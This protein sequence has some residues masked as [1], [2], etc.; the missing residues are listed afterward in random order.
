METNKDQSK[1]EEIY[2][3]KAEDVS[4]KLDLEENVTR[5]NYDGK[6]LIL[7]G[8]AHV[9]KQSVELVK[10][11][12]ETEQPDS[13]CVELDQDRYHSLKNPK[14]WEETDIVQVIKSKK[15]AYLLATL[16]LG[17][18]QRRIA[19]KLDTQVG[20][21]MIQGIESAE[22][23]NANL[24]LADRSIQITFMRIWRKLSFK[25]K[26]KLFYGLVFSSADDADEITDDQLQDLLK[27]DM[28]ESA[29]SE[30][31]G[32]FPII[33]QVLINERDQHLAFKIREAP[34]PKIVAILGA[35]HVPGI[36]EEIYKTSPEDLA[37]ITQ[38]PPKKSYSKAIGWVIPI[39]I[40]ALIVYGFVTNLETGLEQLSSWFLWNS[41]LAG[42]GTLLALGHPLSILTAFVIA[43]F[44]SLNPFL[45]CGWFAGLVEASVRKPT[46]SDVQNVYKDIF[47]LKGIFK[48]RFLKIILVVIMA[49]IGSSIGTIV[50][51]LDIVTNL[52]G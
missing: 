35:A 22:S 31:R 45:A 48:N 24:V 28:L 21:E 47:S 25:E 19:K 44:S 40:I 46:V 27:E 11:I 52:F 8:T 15:V 33:G 51:G 32:E 37:E 6:E 13:I 43:P 29:L 20:Q 1:V 12:I 10:A 3:E 23:L 30:V 50:A 9:S 5:L 16:I 34:G 38:I 17:A 39:L 18:Y 7:I 14:A 49:N 36:K 2:Q 4:L 26:F 42:L 41:C